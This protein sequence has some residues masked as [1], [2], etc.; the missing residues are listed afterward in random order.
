MQRAFRAILQGAAT[1]TALCGERVD[2]G[3]R[4]SNDP[5][6]AI[7]LHLIGD[8]EGHTLQGRDG[9]SGA[10]VQVDCYGATYAEAGAV[11]EAVRDALDGYRQ[12]GFRG[13]FLDARRDNSERGANEA[14]RPFRVTLDFL[15]HW[16]SSNG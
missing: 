2:W 10:R 11:A 8:G 16:R 7:C 4:P 3:K 12:D 1:V 15:T 9:L 6:P 14:D 5:Y 13:I